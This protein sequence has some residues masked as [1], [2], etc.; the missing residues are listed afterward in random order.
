MSTQSSPVG[1]M[2][3]IEL[4][5]CD[6]AIISLPGEHSRRGVV[7]ARCRALGLNPRIVEAVACEPGQ[8][9]CGLSHIKALR[10]WDGTRP[11]L[12]LEDDVNTTEHFS[13]AIDVPADADAVWLGIT[14]Y[15]AAES[16]EFVGFPGVLAAETVAPGVARIYNMLAAHAV[17]H[18][19]RHWSRS[20]IE[21][22]LAAMLEY[23][24]PP[25]CGLARIQPD[26]RIYAMQDPLFYQA[27]ELQ[28]REVATLREDAT[29]IRLDPPQPGTVFALE[30][31]EGLKPVRLERIDGI[32][33]WIDL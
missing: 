18:L 25:D 20:A 26:F 13:P 16:V 30:L 4:A 7:A 33:R 8:I 2:T 19:T 1:P 21:A 11:L 32:L 17:L 14:K 9:G 31:R 15:G 10:S 5:D 22:M 27:A 12:V 3:R 29:R 6:V 28:R 23:G 24:S